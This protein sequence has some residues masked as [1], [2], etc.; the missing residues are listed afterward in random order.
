MSIYIEGKI[1]LR[2]SVAL[3]GAKNSAIKLIFASMFCNEDVIL[4]NVPR[5]ESILIDLEIIKSIGGKAEWIGKNRLLLNGANINTYEIP[6]ELGAKY[7]TAFLLVGPLLYKFGK[8]QIPQT[9]GAFFRPSPINR[10]IATWQSL[11]FDIKQ[12]EQW[13]YISSNNPKATE[14]SFK[15]T[16]HTGTENAIMSSLFLDGETIINNASEEPEIEDLLHFAHSMGATC[17]RIEPRKIRIVGTNVFHGTTYEIQPD[18]YEAAAL[19]TAALL[20]KGNIAIMGINKLPLVPFVNFL[21]KIKANFDMQYSELRV[22][23]SN[24]LDATNVTVAPSPGFVPD[25]Q[26]LATLILSKAM[27]TSFIHDTVYTNRFGYVKDL[28]RMGT[29]IELMKPSSQNIVPVISDDSYDYENDGEP[30]TL[31]KVVGPCKLT[32]A[33]FHIID[34]R[35]ANTL[36]LAGLGAEGKTE[37]NGY[38]SA[39][40]ETENFFDKLISLGAKITRDELQDSDTTSSLTT[41]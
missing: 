33:K 15:T 39:F 2:G 41:K 30:L 19:A 32:G 22:W 29:D 14:I 9:T 10:I 21:T 17:E 38:V 31:A 28:N 24:N 36:V 5:I 35:Y 12:D 1:P 23:D 16:S 7:R 34:P 11:G 6:Y 18:K 13:I 37:I 4:D 25:W 20:T 3:S 40:E 26:P 8:A 27:G